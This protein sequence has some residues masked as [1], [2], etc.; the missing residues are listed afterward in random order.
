[1]IKAYALLHKRPDI[2]A[3]Q[4]HEHWSTIHREHALRIDQ[5]RRYVQAHRV[6]PGIAGI[7]TA[8]Y[9]GIP[10]VWYDSLESAASQS[11][12]PN[13]TEFAKKDEP[14]FVDVSRARSVVTT[15]RPLHAT[16]GLGEGTPA[17]KVI[18]MV[19]RPKGTAVEDFQAS[20]WAAAE[21]LTGLCAGVHRTAAAVTLPETYGGD[22]PPTYDG[23]AELWWP[24]RA[25]LDAAWATDGPAVLAAVGE[26]ADLDAS[27]AFAC[28]ELRV[29]WPGDDVPHTAARAGAH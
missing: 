12:D 21:R 6:E 14:N 1:M 22:E 15:H 28:R 23:F 26:V 5:L 18:L 9:D 19:R 25:A 27:H 8:P 16:V 7:A 3:E 17:A 4:F 29:I 11:D 13:Y 20:W 10:E 2:S 24:D